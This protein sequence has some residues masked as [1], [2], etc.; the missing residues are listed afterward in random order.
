M[1][2][3]NS[4]KKVHIFHTSSL[5]LAAFSV[6][7]ASTALNSED[8][9]TSSP[10]ESTCKKRQEEDPQSDDVSSMLMKKLRLDVAQLTAD[11]VDSV[12]Q[13]TIKELSTSHRTGSDL[14]QFV[15][16]SPRSPVYS[17]ERQ[18][19]DA[20]H[21]AE[22]PLVRLRTLLVS[23]PA[24]DWEPLETIVV[25][26][27][28]AVMKALSELDFRAVKKSV[29][30][31]EGSYCTRFLLGVDGK[32]Y[33]LAHDAR[34]T[35]ASLVRQ[36]VCDDAPA[37]CCFQP[38]PATEL[39]TSIAESQT[40]RESFE[41]VVHRGAG[42]N[43]TW[44]IPLQ[45]IATVYEREP[46]ADDGHVNSILP[47]ARRVRVP[48]E[49]YGRDVVAYA[50][51]IAERRA[52]AGI[53]L[54]QRTV[55]LHGQL[56]S[57]G[58][59]RPGWRVHKRMGNHLLRSVS[60]LDYLLQPM[61]SRG[62]IGP[63]TIRLSLDLNCES[64]RSSFVEPPL[65]DRNGELPVQFLEMPAHA[66]TGDDTDRWLDWQPGPRG[67]LNA[68]E[69]FTEFARQVL[70]PQRYNAMRESGYVSFSQG[71]QF[72][73]SK[74]A[75]E[76]VSLDALHKIME[77]M[78]ATETQWKQRMFY[79]EFL[80]RSLLEV[81]PSPE[82]PEQL[83]HCKHDKPM[84][85]LLEGQ[86]TS[87]DIASSNDADLNADF[88]VIFSHNQKEYE[89]AALGPVYGRPGR[90]GDR[91]SPWRP[92]LAE[93]TAD[94][95]GHVYRRPPWR[96]PP[97][98]RPSLLSSGRRDFSHTKDT[99]D[100]EVA[101]C[102]TG[103]LR[104]ADDMA[105]TG[106][107]EKLLKA[108]GL[109]VDIFV[110]ATTTNPKSREVLASSPVASLLRDVRLQSSEQSQ[111]SLMELPSRYNN[112]KDLQAEWSQATALASSY[113]LRKCLELIEDAETARKRPYRFL[114]RTRT[115]LKWL[116]NHPPAS[117]LDE[118][119]C[120]IPEGED[121]GGVNDR[122]A[123]CGRQA[124]DTYFR[125]WDAAAAG[126]LQPENLEKQLGEYLEGRH[127]PVGRFANVAAL[128]C[129]PSWETHCHSRPL[130]KGGCVNG[131]KYANEIKSARSNARLLEGE[132][133]SWAKHA[134]QLQRTPIS[135][136]L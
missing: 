9:C 18:H 114:V 134:D 57:F 71:A 76:Q 34:Q 45:H 110:Y 107:P 47:H 40:S 87:S 23:V 55:F 73:T 52:P 60:L 26:H 136:H 33:V 88:G 111:A 75:L 3:S 90:P 50:M 83:G 103:S 102:L 27:S 101:V 106:L 69:E 117:M 85:V 82:P 21:Y 67:W 38:T 7:A 30:N 6:L 13:A 119:H 4:R 125:V 135:L 29:P 133:G 42:E 31:R 112:D 84:N 121:Y 96:R 79:M 41:V 132:G 128:L 37:I 36:E 97:Q 72:A 51:H 54:A 122:H 59:W 64:H 66:P 8:E 89:N 109:P 16:F 131:F 123:F 53:G 130:E 1:T 95:L 62:Y 24:I 81:G 98:R 58:F 65:P 129:C 5:V 78:K 94:T 99:N 15:Q 80:W 92:S 86:M 126:Y 113:E 127:V 116:A 63:L 2:G 120:W 77:K 44:L 91:V 56:P 49:F 14:P 104:Y 11:V 93:K 22:A 32:G 46:Y 48:S 68:S 39:L 61:N 12:H 118:S 35:Y 100:A 20:D 10:G 115:D 19:A 70:P 124:G 25:N 43:L 108:F 17:L 105:D 74:E 28:H